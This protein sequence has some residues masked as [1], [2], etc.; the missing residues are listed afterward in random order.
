MIGV[1]LPTRSATAPVATPPARWTLARAPELLTI[2]VVAALLLGIVLRFVVGRD[3]PL[4]IDE[5]W[6]GGV[7]SQP[8]LAAMLEQ[9]LLDANA[10]VYYVF[11]YL[12]TA[13]FGLSDAALRFPSLVF[14]VGAPLV[15]L[16]ATKGM[17]RT[18]RLTWCGLIALWVPALWYAQEAR[19]YSLVLC[20]ATACTVAHVRLLAQPSMR[21]TV[22]W[23]S[24]GTLAIL[25]QYHALVL[26]G[27]Q[28]LG[29]LALHRERALRTWPAAL[30]F[31]PAAVWIVIHYPRLSEF[32]HSNAGWQPLLELKHV[33]EIVDFVIGDIRLAVVLAVLVA[34]LLVLARRNR[35]ASQPAQVFEAQR[36]AIVAALAAIAGA[37]VTIV[38]GV[39]LPSFTT[40]YLMPFMPGVLLGFALVT[41]HFGR[42]WAA[43]PAAAVLLYGIFA[44]VW[45]DERSRATGKSFNFEYAS[46]ELAKSGVDHLAFL[47]DN[48]LTP[49]LQPSQLEA[50]GGFFFRRQ[51]A[52]PVTAVI[53]RPGD[54]PNDR[55]LAAARGN[56]P[57]LLWLYDS[58]VHGTAAISHPP[59]IERHDPAWVCR[60]FGKGSFG[61]IA[62]HRA[63]R[64]NHPARVRP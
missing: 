42:R 15:A 23:A 44:L 32:A 54:D 30:V 36:G 22:I 40:R 50:M 43:V 17:D 28:G 12:W 38:V 41:T 49:V 55:L 11:M 35:P 63:T 13:L 8:T 59:R 19:C 58:N 52:V 20:L 60:N 33:P 51:H 61:V 27:C 10:P 21:A 5:T 31:V 24:L 7:I 29:Y 2:A 1:E 48:P 4:W 45:A 57:A 46:S 56:H 64:A 9:S 25:T 16:L 53:L 37:I 47:W 3:L 39:L 62:C 34:I 6:T 18:T 26:V 14:G